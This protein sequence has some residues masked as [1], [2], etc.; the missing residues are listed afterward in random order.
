M[1]DRYKAKNGDV[2]AQFRLAKIYEV[3]FGELAQNFE[4][5]F[6]WFKLAAENGHAEAQFKLGLMYEKGYG[7]TQNY[8]KAE[9]CYK[10]AAKKGHAKAQAALIQKNDYLGNH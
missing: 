4:A 10:L 9:K 7:V 6:K 3:G 2:E 8:K 5:A 1:W